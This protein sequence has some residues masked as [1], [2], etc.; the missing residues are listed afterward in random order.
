MGG[1]IL[2]Y[3]SEPSVTTGFP[4]GRRVRVGD[5]MKVAEGC[6]QRFAD[7]VLLAMK[8]E[9]RKHQEPGNQVVGRL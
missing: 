4:R 9:R 6:S 5:V 7:A 8:M 2:D 1:M 3:H